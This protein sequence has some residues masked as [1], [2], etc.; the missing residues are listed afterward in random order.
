MNIIML[1]KALV[2]Q[3]INTDTSGL[4]VC[5]ENQ[6]LS[7]ILSLSLSCEHLRQSRRKCFFANNIYVLAIVGVKT[8]RKHVW[9][10]RRTN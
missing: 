4:R 1:R 2:R 7:L 5:R 9:P 3:E 6:F 8:G 10:R